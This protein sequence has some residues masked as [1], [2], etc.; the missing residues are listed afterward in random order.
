MTRYEADNRLDLML[1]LP[2][3]DEKTVRE[4]HGLR[5]APELGDVQL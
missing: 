5:A 1:E 2:M 4:N 3:I